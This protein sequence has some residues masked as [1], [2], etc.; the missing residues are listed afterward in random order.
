MYEADVEFAWDERKNLANQRKHRISF[1]TAV[2]VFDDPFHLST[3]DRVVDGEL[4]W[5]TIGTVKGIQVVLVAHT[6][7]EDA[8]VVRILSARKATR[9]ERNIYAQSD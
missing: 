5:Q 9:R 1:E 3:Q 6:V 4:R 8:E 7:D 2:W